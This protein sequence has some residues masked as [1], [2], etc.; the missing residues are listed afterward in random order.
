[1]K[2]I[3]GLMLLFKQEIKKVEFHYNYQC[4]QSI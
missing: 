3:I 1:M 4:A 2:D